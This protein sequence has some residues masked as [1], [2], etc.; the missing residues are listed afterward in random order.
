MIVLVILPLSL[1]FVTSNYQVDC[2][3]RG[4][5]AARVS[6]KFCRVEVG[7]GAWLNTNEMFNA[8]LQQTTTDIRLRCYCN[9]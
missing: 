4:V 6:I 8:L 3:F 5:K 9:K 1:S 7:L 2:F